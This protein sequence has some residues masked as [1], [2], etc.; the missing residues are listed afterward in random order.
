MKKFFKTHISNIKEWF[1]QNESLKFNLT[2]DELIK[3]FVIIIPI[4]AILYLYN[5]YGE[6][7]TQYF[8]YFNPIDFINIFY[9]NNITL[10]IIILLLSFLLIH[11]LLNFEIL[12]LLKTKAN[13][14][15]ST[16]FIISFIF[17][18]VIWYNIDFQKF[19]LLIFMSIIVFVVAIKYKQT[20][21]IY[22]SI[23]FIYFLY[24][25][26]LAKNDAFNTKTNK[27]NFDI[28]LNDNTFALKQEQ[29]DSIHKDYFVGK[30]TDYI[31]IYNDSLKAIRVIPVNEI[32]E[33]RFPIIK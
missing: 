6:F 31:F 33:I 20:R 29:T 8:L 32:K 9:T 13:L 24:T 30:I 21:L 28:I 5:Y 14:V 16:L 15:L 25:I 11:S 19:Y 17:L 22:F 1:N 10:L 4:H 12:N 23:I 26:R 18:F 2:L 27:P 7:G 3:S